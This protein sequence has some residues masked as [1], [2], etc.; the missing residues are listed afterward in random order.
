MLVSLF[1]SQPGVRCCPR[2]CIFGSHNRKRIG[3]QEDHAMQV[4][5][6]PAVSLPMFYFFFME[7]KS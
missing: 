5:L 4:R 3:I 2:L 7:Q 1:Q 6:L